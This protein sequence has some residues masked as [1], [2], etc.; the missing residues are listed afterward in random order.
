[1]QQ[2][3]VLQNTSIHVVDTLPWESPDLAQT[4]AYTTMDVIPGTTYVR[5]VDIYIK[6]GYESA[7][8]HEVGHALSNAGHTVYW[9]CFRPEFIQIFQK[10]RYN[11]VMMAQGFDN[12]LEYFAC[13]YDMFIRNPEILKKT[14]PETFDY[15]TVVMR[16]TEEGNDGSDNNTAGACTKCGANSRHVGIY[17]NNNGDRQSYQCET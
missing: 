1:M 11:N 2:N 6:T 16:Y 4:W 14:N 13:A 15:L 7:L 12:I 5:S 9:W 8:T 17:K 3:L 10:E